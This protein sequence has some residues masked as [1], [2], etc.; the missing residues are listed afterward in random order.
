[1]ALHGEKMPGPSFL[2]Q[3][4]VQGR[5]LYGLLLR[6]A[7]LRQGHYR[8]GH[9]LVLTEVLWMSTVLGIIWYFIGHAPP[10]GDSAVFYMFTGMFP[11]TLF[12]MLHTRVSAALEANRGLLVYP[13]VRPVDTLLA[14]AGLE[15][16][17]QLV[18]FIIFTAAFV[19]IGYANF[20][21][22]PVEMLA[23]IGMVI[24]LGFGT[25]VSSM[26]LRDLWS[27]WA[28]IN[29]MLVRV[30]FF[31]SGIFYQVEY[32]PPQIR[33]VLVWNPLVHAIEWVRYCIFSGYSTQILDR[34]YL[35][36]WA[37][38]ASV[39]GLAMERLRRPRLLE[40]S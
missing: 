40:Q 20:P 15:S 28:T 36:F 34:E 13:V 12:R 39:F 18:A 26:I 1:M 17:F 9:L 33:D 5:V 8:L 21:A 19:W 3:L 37:L 4:K 24:L 27:P 23:A 6:E 7:S 31:V 30:L 25:G 14:R 11:F 32:L 38:G 2:Q 16:A 10:Y 29:N 22:R 35:M